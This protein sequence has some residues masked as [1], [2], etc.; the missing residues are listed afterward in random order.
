MV[1]P[2][3]PGGSQLAASPRPGSRA[4]AARGGGLPGWCGPP[5]IEFGAGGYLVSAAI[6]ADLQRELGMH[7]DQVV[8]DDHLGRISTSP[9]NL[10][11]TGWI[12]D[13]VGP[14]DFL[15]VLGDG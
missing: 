2:G 6:A 14:N 12:A 4:A 5:Q 11:I 7:L 10:W 15:G 3:I 8:Y 1:P 13:Y 9:P